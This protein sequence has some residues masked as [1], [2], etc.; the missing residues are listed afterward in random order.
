[1]SVDELAALRTAPHPPT[2]LDVRED[3]EVAMAALTGAVHVPTGEL[4]ALIGRG[5]DAVAT[6]IGAPA[7]APIVVLCKTG[8][9]SAFATAR[10]REIGFTG[11]RDLTGGIDEWARRID[12]A[13]PRY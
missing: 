9:R 3:D 5:A 2:V 13:M 10:L 8:I 7:D 12:P 11:A 1:V 6:R 4:L